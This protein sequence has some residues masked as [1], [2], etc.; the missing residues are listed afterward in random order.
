[1]AVDQRAPVSPDSAAARLVEMSVDVRT[2]VVADPAGGLI[3][4][5]DDLDPQQAR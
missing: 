5:S 4:A 1:M 3:A 2:A